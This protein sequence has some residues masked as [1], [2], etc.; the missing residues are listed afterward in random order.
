MI[1]EG[2]FLK[3]LLHQN[4]VLFFLFLLTYL[5]ILLYPPITQLPPQFHSLI[6]FLPPFP[7]AFFPFL[8]T[9]KMVVPSIEM[10]K[11]EKEQALEGK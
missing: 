1:P 8:P 5:P 10:V 4:S 2:N 7:S 9:W 6:S 3:C 11:T